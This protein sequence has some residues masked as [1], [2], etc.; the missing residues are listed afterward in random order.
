MKLALLFNTVAIRRILVENRGRDPWDTLGVSR[1]VIISAYSEQLW[2]LFDD[3]HVPTGFHIALWEI[4]EEE[5]A[6]E[7]REL[8]L[9]GGVG[10]YTPSKALVDECLKLI[11]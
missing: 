4:D 6:E 9:A 11:K 10:F 1:P 5:E 7:I 2:A 3:H 8:F